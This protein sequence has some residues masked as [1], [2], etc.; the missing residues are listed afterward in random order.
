MTSQK[1]MQRKG[2]QEER[3][4]ELALTVDTSDQIKK[5]KF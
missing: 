4:E 2:P 3:I 1:Q 5:I